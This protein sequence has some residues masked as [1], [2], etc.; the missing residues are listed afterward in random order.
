MMKQ[1]SDLSTTQRSSVVY[2][3]REL[4]ETAQYGFQTPKWHR[5]CGSIYALHHYIAGDYDVFQ[6]RANMTITN[7]DASQ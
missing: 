3:F 5:R 2:K 4:M 6:R 1:F 7:R